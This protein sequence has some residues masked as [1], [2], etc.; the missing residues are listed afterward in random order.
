MRIADLLSFAGM[1]LTYLLTFV[2]FALAPI[3][4]AVLG[5]LIWSM[6]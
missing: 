5:A 6:I 1:C 3:I 2:C 4:L